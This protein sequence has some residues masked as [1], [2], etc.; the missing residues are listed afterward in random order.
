LEIETRPKDVLAEIQ[1]LHDRVLQRQAAAKLGASRSQALCCSEQGTEKCEVVLDIAVES[2][3]QVA[4]RAMRA[5]LAALVEQPTPADAIAVL[6]HTIAACDNGDLVIARVLG[7][8]RAVVDQHGDRRHPRSEAARWFMING[9]LLAD[10]KTVWAAYGMLILADELT[11]GDAAFVE[12][13]ERVCSRYARIYHD[14]AVSWEWL[15]ID[16]KGSPTHYE[17]GTRP[18]RRQSSLAL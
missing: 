1:R 16:E 6:R 4:W 12:V 11:V 13:A 2:A 15:T 17:I 5:E 8:A 14:P 9:V 3:A 10:G 7:H 18:L